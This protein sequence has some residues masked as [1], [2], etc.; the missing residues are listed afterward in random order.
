[1]IGYIEKCFPL[2]F[3]DSDLEITCSLELEKVI[4]NNI[5]YFLDKTNIPVDVF[6]NYI[7]RGIGLHKL[8]LDSK[9]EGFLC[10]AVI[11]LPRLICV[12]KGLV[13]TDLFEL[14]H[15]DIFLATNYDDIK[16]KLGELAEKILSF[17]IISNIRDQIHFAFLK[18]NKIYKDNIDIYIQKT[19]E[20][21]SKI[22][23]Y[24]HYLSDLTHKDKQEIFDVI[25]SIKEKYLG[26]FNFYLDE[27]PK[28]ITEEIL[29]N[30]F[31][32][33]NNYTQDEFGVKFGAGYSG[34]V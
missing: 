3:S 2:G 21:T 17:Y 20:T 26:L 22:N 4:K 19:S 30:D 33:M 25:S 14:E 31:E 8:F 6:E 7:E 27:I 18:L 15:S 24:V 13:Y 12:E 16:S 29:L 28:E 34:I 9:L 32:T 23:V 5:D 10:E 11:P 1:M